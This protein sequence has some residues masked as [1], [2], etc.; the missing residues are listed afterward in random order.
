MLTS[1]PVLR[2]RASP[3]TCNHRATLA[4][5]ACCRPFRPRDFNVSK[6]WAIGVEY[7]Y[8]IGVNNDLAK[9]HIPEVEPRMDELAGEDGN[10][11]NFGETRA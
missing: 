5:L 4:L 11:T 2:I 1:Q 7:A 10:T 6:G 8:M 3:G 9:R